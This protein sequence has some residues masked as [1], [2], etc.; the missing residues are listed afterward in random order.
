M[1]AVSHVG[2]LL[3]APFGRLRMPVPSLRA[4]FQ[5]AAPAFSRRGDDQRDALR[6]APACCAVGFRI[7]TEAGN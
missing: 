5:T 2:E 4:P 3:R 6:D 7:L 1:G